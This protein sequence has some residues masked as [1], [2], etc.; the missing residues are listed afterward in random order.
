VRCEID[1]LVVA[2]PSLPGGGDHARAILGVAPGPGG[3]HPRMGT[4]DHQLLRLADAAW[5][6]G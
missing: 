6:L 1:H 3:A 5:R 2:A 4:H